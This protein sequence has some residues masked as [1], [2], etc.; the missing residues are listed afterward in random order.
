MCAI[1]ST[2]FTIAID[3]I[4]VLETTT[5]LADYYRALPILSIAV[6]AVLFSRP[7]FLFE[8]PKHCVRLL[9][10]S[11]QL[12]NAVLFHECLLHACG[13]W[14]EPRYLTL[15][16]GKIRAACET[17]YGKMCIKTY[18]AQNQL[19]ESIPNH[20]EV[21]R[22][23]V[24]LVSKCMDGPRIV[25]PYYYRTLI[26]E[27]GYIPKVTFAI[28]PLMR[29]ALVLEWFPSHPGVGGREGLEY[30]DFFFCLE[31]DDVELPWD[32]TQVDW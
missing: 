16:E 28:V 8:I 18:K 17:A 5:T 21:G 9:S 6:S 29:N 12:R 24:A 15:P 26:V 13:P 27:L 4:E 10:I 32:V 19:L 14:T 1:H 11:A 7:D 25:I 30:K 22:T 23:M 20:D 3:G 2:P 31:R